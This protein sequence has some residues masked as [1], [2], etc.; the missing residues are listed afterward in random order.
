VRAG[1]RAWQ[2][3]ALRVTFLA[4]LAMTVTAAHDLRFGRVRY[5]RSNNQGNQRAIRPVLLAFQL[6]G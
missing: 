5:F 4:V 3:G 6:S 1:A 2:S